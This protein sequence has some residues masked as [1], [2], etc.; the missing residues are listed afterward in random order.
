MW[1]GPDTYPGPS[2]GPAKMSWPA[3]RLVGTGAYAPRALQGN[4]SDEIFPERTR[5]REDPHT[6]FVS[7]IG[8]ARMSVTHTAGAPLT[9]SAPRRGPAPDS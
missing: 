2:I 1:R 7:G 3:P 5:R 9:S 4:F 6:N 8:P